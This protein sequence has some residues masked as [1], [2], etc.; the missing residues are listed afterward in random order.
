[1]MNYRIVQNSGWVKLWQINYLR[2]LVR[3][4][5]KLVDFVIATL[6][7]MEFGWVRYW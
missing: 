4:I 2:V 7:N 6:V 3:K 5:F 1:M